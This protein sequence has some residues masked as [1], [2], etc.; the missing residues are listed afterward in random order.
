MKD[1]VVEL[2]VPMDNLET[3][4]SFIWGMC[5]VPF[6]E[7]VKARDISCGLVGI[8]ISYHGLGFGYTREGFELSRKVVRRRAKCR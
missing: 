6:H 4:L 1:K 2:V 5:A 3:R 7:F 8:N